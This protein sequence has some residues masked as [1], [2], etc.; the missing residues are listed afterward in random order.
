MN[1]RITRRG[2][3]G[4]LAASAVGLT[5]GDLS[6]LEAGNKR[7][8]KLVDT[9]KC[10]GC[11]AC[12]SSCKSWNK[13]K[14][15]LPEEFPMRE[16]TLSGHTWVVVMYI[17]GNAKN[18]EEQ[19]YIHWACQHCGK[20]ACA[21]VCPV[22]AIKKYE[23]GPVVVNEKKCIGC[24]YCYQACPYKIPRFDFEKRVTR[25]CT[26]CYDRIP[27]VQPACVAACP[28]QAL[29]FGTRVDMLMKGKERAGEI[30]GYLLGE[31]EAGG[32]D[33]LTIFR[34]RPQDYGLIVAPKKVVNQD[35]DKVRISFSGFSAAAV[36]AGLLYLYSKQGKGK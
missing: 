36:L 16:Q 33:V 18:V 32:T 19:S 3:L 25:K 34:N 10:I 13:L 8:A 4:G 35:V 5:A 29:D 31:Y 23:H 11:K 14:S 7:Y 20:P 28:V 1:K 9:T 12:M 22:S 15:Y 26:L 30:K 6:L 24:R 2:F 21:G 27:T 17:K